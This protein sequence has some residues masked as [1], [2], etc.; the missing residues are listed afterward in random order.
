MDLNMDWKF[1][2]EMSARTYKD[3][4]CLSERLSKIAKSRQVVSNFCHSEQKVPFAEG[5]KS[6]L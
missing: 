3:F 4:V 6:F 5:E 2:Q 1:R